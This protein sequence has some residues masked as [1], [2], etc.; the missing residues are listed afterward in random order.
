MCNAY[1]KRGRLIIVYAS[2]KWISLLMN[3]T[4]RYPSSSWIYRLILR[5]EEELYL[6]E[7]FSWVQLR[8]WGITGKIISKSLLVC[9]LIVCIFSFLYNDKEGAALHAS[10]VETLDILTTKFSHCS[11]TDLEGA[12]S[13]TISNLVLKFSC[14]FF[15]FFFYKEGER[16]LHYFSC[17][18]SV[19]CSKTKCNR[20]DPMR[21]YL[22]F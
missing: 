11:M 19:W 12:F 20:R 6:W 15:D 13:C 14:F 1:P 3:W 21:M 22:L 4:E 16:H 9:D 2:D 17:S 7:L 10:G 5:N 18:K 8:E